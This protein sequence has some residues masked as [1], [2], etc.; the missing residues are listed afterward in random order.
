MAELRARSTRATS[1]RPLSSTNTTGATSG[2][3]DGLDAALLDAFVYVANWCVADSPWGFRARCSP[4]NWPVSKLNRP[5]D[6]P[7]FRYW[8]I[9]WALNEGDDYGRF[10]CSGSGWMGRLTPL[11]DELLRGDRRALYLGWLAGV[12]AGG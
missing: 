1:R 4:A 3:S 5:D 2:R 11:R 9:E 7:V 6:R 12:T 10:A 8:I